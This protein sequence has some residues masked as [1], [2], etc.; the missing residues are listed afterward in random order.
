VAA[1]ALLAAGAAGCSS[2][3]SGHPAA[4]GSAPPGVAT[5]MKVPAK[6]GPLTRGADGPMD[7]T[8][9]NIP[10]SVLKN[11]RAVNYAA[12]GGGDGQRLARFGRWHG[13][14]HPLRR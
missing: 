8:G 2:G 3:S 9:G 5:G 6:I 12:D 13:R 1:M 10:K 4:G 14:V 7:A 11:L